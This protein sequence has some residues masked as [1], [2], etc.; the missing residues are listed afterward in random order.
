[1]IYALNKFDEDKGGPWPAEIEEIHV[2]RKKEIFYTLIK[3][4]LINYFY[5]FCF[6]SM[7]LEST[8]NGYG[9]HARI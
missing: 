9:E 8:K 6:T 5:D 1:M 4:F 7:W 2:G 3:P